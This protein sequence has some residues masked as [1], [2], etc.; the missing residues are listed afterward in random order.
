MP[1]IETGRTPRETTFSPVAGAGR[2][3]EVESVWFQ[4]GD[5][6]A[7]P[8]AVVGIPPAASRDAYD[9]A[10]RL[11]GIGA[12][13]ESRPVRVIDGRGVSPFDAAPI[14]ATLVD[15]VANGPVL[16]VVDPPNIDQGGVP[17]L[18]RCRTIL[19]AVTVGGSRQRDLEQVRVMLPESVGVVA[20]MVDRRKRR[21]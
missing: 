19:L 21:S 2:N 10:V 4:L 20:V 18:Q 3:H 9:F 6:A 14:A 12:A 15:K 1:S 11:A 13:I 7:S 5:M 17:I 16:V 8:V